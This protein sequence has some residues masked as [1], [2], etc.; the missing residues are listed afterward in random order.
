M[1]D[2]LPFARVVPT[3]LLLG[4]G[5]VVA[6][7]GAQLGTE[8]LDTVKVVAARWEL[9]SAA[10]AIEAD[11]VSHG[12]LPGSRSLADFGA[13][14]RE[15]LRSNFGRDPALDLWQNPYRYRRLGS[16][17]AV[18]SYGP[19]G[20]RDACARAD[21]DQ[22]AAEVAAAVARQRQ[23]QVAATD[24]EDDDVCVVLDLAGLKPSGGAGIPGASSYDNPYRQIDNR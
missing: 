7:S 1:L 17:I 16:D 4:G 20:R 10:R 14:L 24:G 15:N 9:S 21:P 5:A 8:V 22:A 13:Y 19:N 18:I 6:H 12:A 23:G 3:L 11:F 2:Q